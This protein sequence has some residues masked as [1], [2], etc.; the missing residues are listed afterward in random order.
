MKLIPKRLRDQTTEAPSDPVQPAKATVKLVPKAKAPI[1]T[2]APPPGADWFWGEMPAVR[3]ATKKAGKHG[4][5]VYCAL[6]ILIRKARFSH[7]NHFSASIEEIMELTGLGRNSVCDAIKILRRTKL[8]TVLSGDMRGNSNLYTLH[9]A[10]LPEGQPRFAGQTTRVCQTNDLGLPDKHQEKGRKDS[11]PPEEESL[12]SEKS[13]KGADA[14]TPL[15]DAKG[16]DSAPPGK[17]PKPSV[18]T[19]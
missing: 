18:N 10:G 3:M 7:K 5:A 1:R 6:C 12:S 16:S 4:F 2:Q 8:V 19:F 17:K 13:E 11:P 14:G 15:A 9:I